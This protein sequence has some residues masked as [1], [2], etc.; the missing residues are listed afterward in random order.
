MID[1]ILISKEVRDEM[2]TCEVVED[3]ETETWTDHKLVNLCMEMQS[4]TSIK[5]Q[6]RHRSKDNGKAADG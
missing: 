5:A 2:K 3:A 4:K 6:T 1:Y